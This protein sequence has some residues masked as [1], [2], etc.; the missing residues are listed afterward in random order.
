M[1]LSRRTFLQAASGLLMK[2]SATTRP[3]SGVTNQS[4]HPQWLHGLSLFGD[5]K[6][7][8]N[9]PHFD[10]VN[11]RAPKAGAVRQ[12]VSG[13]FDNFNMAVDGR[14]GILVAGIDLVYETLLTSSLDEVSSAYG[15]LAEAVR[16]PTDFSSVTYRL[17]RVAKWHDG[18]PITPED[19]VFSFNAFK[20][21]NPRLAAYYRHV[22][23]A[24]ITG[25]QD[26]TFIFDTAGNRELPQIVG[27]LTVLPK[28]WWFA[29]DKS[30]NR[31]KIGDTTLEVPLGS[32]PY[33]VKSLDAG[34]S[35][36]YQRVPDY[37]GKELNVRA[38]QENFDEL[39]FDYYRDN[40]VEFEA[41]K[42]G[43]FDWRIENVARNWATGYDFPAVRER[44]VVLKS[45]R[46][47]TSQSCRR[48]R[49]TPGV[50]NLPMPACA[51]RS[52]SHS[53]TRA[54]TGIYSSGSTRASRVIFRAP[55]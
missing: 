22:M 48:S 32:G 12:G 9:F 29:A 26:V 38:G 40:A 37:W 15:L 36:I 18:S 53:T 14:K 1:S 30:G 24:Q 43:A 52:I 8:P 11:P 21:H 35:I 27:Q 42:A 39:R 55:N 46:S 49:S 54:S 3:I 45:F 4:D 44:R 47:A 51:A 7:P 2:P 13:T 31:R 17:R 20:K 6:Y 41:F 23:S 50:A 33:R 10:Y 34:H 25:P 19:V 16:H 28:H 5:L